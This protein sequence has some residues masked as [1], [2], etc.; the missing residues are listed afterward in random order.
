MADYQEE[1]LFDD[2]Y[3]DEP[4]S[5][6]TPAAAAPPPPPP[7]PAEPEPKTEP[8]SAPPQETTQDAAPSWPESAVGGNDTNMDASAYDNAQND[9][10]NYGPINVKEDG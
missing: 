2:L 10:D 3:D 5:K 8:Q 7:P 6:P 4:A 1:D 9:D